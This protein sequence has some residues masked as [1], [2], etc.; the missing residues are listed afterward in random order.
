MQG[1]AMWNLLYI[2]YIVFHEQNMIVNIKSEIYALPYR[3][4]F[5]PSYSRAVYTNIEQWKVL[6]FADLKNQFEFSCLLANIIGEYS[7]DGLFHMIL[8][9]YQISNVNYGRSI[10]AML[11]FQH[12]PVFAKHFNFRI[13]WN[14]LPLLSS[15][16]R[17]Q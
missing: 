8:T 10:Q 1:H 17:K 15:S 6:K 14:N 5:H 2:R 4:I 16:N 13:L 12:W 11:L 9:M 7:K 3:S